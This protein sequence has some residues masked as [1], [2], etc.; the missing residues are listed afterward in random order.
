MYGIAVRLR[1]EERA[2][3]CDGLEECFAPQSFSPAAMDPSLLDRYVGNQ[4]VVIRKGLRRSPDAA[5]ELWVMRGGRWVIE[6]R[7]RHA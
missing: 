4:T 6:K 2:L 1:S 3:N 7:D 5:R